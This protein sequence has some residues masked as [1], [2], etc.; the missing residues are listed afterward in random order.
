[1]TLG[2]EEL[3]EEALMEGVMLS[4]VAVEFHMRWGFRF[5]WLTEARR[6]M[7]SRSPKYVSTSS[8]VRMM[9]NPLLVRLRSLA[10]TKWTES[11]ARV[12][13]CGPVVITAR[14]EAIGQ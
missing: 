4:G 8:L 9:L 10:Q 2:L 5:F 7:R 3:S 1:M 13:L 14:M 12:D 6:E 11:L